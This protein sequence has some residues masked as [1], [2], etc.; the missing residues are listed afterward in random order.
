M[1]PLFAASAEDPLSPAASDHIDQEGRAGGGLPGRG[2][3]TL[4]DNLPSRRGL[5][6]RR[7]YERA[8]APLGTKIGH[9]SPPPLSLLLLSLASSA[10]PLLGRTSSPLLP[11]RCCGLARPSPQIQ[12]VYFAL[13]V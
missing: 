13:L 11:L 6:W 4:G 12:S 3:L 7:G 2:V 9:L 10:V 5:T 1:S 8:A